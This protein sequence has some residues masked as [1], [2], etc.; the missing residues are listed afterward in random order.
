MGSDG[1]KRQKYPAKQTLIIYLYTIKI[2]ETNC[3][4][5]FC[6]ATLDRLGSPTPVQSKSPS[7]ARGIAG[8][9]VTAHLLPT[10]W[11]PREL[12]SEFAA[13]LQL[14]AVAVSNKWLP[15]HQHP[16]AFSSF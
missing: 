14:T 2:M 1:L 5:S 4:L 3:P 12:V 11:K 7:Q 9:G 6:F 8:C 16:S 10:K 13:H 15:G